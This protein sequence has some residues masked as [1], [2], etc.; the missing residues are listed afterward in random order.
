MKLIAV[1]TGEQEEKYLIQTIASIIPYLDAVILREKQMTEQD[2]SLFI[3]RVL[4]QG[5]PEEKLIIHGHTTLP[6]VKRM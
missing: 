5:V 6:V 1:T 4:A 3:Q 2:Y